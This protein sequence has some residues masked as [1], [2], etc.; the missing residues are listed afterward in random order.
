MTTVTIPM[1]DAPPA[2][3]M[4]LFEDVL[5]PA[6]PLALPPAI[7]ALY[8]RSGDAVVGGQA[9]T[10]DTA[11]FTEDATTVTGT[12]TLWRFEVVHRAPD[13]QLPPEDRARVLLARPLLRDPSLPF[14]LRLDRVNFTPD[15]E[16]PRHGHFGQ[17]IRRLIDG[18]LLLTIGD[19]VE[20]R[21]RDEAWFE[22][23]EEPVAAR[24]LLPGTA[25]I[26]ALVMDATMQG[27]SS[28]RA[29]TP[30]DATRPRGVTYRL[31]LDEVT[32]LR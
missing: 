17:G 14:V 6:S 24:G 23:G 13:W 11:L 5:D 27:Q 12:G 26:R 32:R 21:Q 28:F 31:Y 30:E 29:W 9:L 8:L 10:A 3:L 19:R 22:T 1:T 18:R 7:R 15:V 4:L 25:F 20:R 16:T 2:M